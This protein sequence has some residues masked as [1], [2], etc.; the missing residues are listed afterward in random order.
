MATP[1][2]NSNFTLN[3]L[4]QRELEDAFYSSLDSDEEKEENEKMSIIPRSNQ[5]LLRSTTIKQKDVFTEE[6]RKKLLEK[7]GELR[8][9]HQLK[10]REIQNTKVNWSLLYNLLFCDYFNMLKKKKIYGQSDNT[11]N[12][13]QEILF[14]INE[15]ELRIKKLLDKVNNKKSIELDPKKTTQKISLSLPTAKWLDTPLSS[16]L[17]PNSISPSESGNF[18]P[19]YITAFNSYLE[20]EMGSKPK[21]NSPA[22]DCIPSTSKFQSS[23]Q[24]KQKPN[25]IVKRQS[26]SNIGV[27]LNHF[28]LIKKTE[29]SEPQTPFGRSHVNH[30][31]GKSVKDFTIPQ[32]QGDNNVLSSNSKPQT[33]IDGNNMIQGGNNSCTKEKNNFALKYKDILNNGKNL[34]KL[35]KKYPQYENDILN[36]KNNFMTYDIEL[37][38]DENLFF[39]PLNNMNRHYLDFHYDSEALKNAKMNKKH[40]VKEKILSHARKIE[41]F[42]NDFNELMDNDEIRKEYSNYEM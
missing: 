14:N 28:P 12:D 26:H 8:R 19:S 16:I 2:I 41:N 15:V 22:A 10:D 23:S 30:K 5:K 25:I 4:Q 3:I 24:I 32:Y 33:E 38:K 9:F 39:D 34:K 21:N 27:F 6:K 36:I 42:I 17:K 7:M 1:V 11:K 20:K 13:N 29:I 31:S 35:I 40:Q 37:N 18:L